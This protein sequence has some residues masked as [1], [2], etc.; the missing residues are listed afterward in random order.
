M[1]VRR[2]FTVFD[3][4][5]AARADLANWRETAKPEVGGTRYEAH[6][7][8]WRSKESV[9]EKEDGR[10]VADKPSTSVAPA[11]FGCLPRRRLLEI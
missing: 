4:S 1:H 11:M 8:G 10:V 5:P 9:L 6:R 3:R 7:K 2:G